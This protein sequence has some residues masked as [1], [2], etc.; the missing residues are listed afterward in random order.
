MGAGDHG[1]DESARPESRHARQ[2]DSIALCAFLSVVARLLGLRERQLAWGVRLRSSAR[3]SRDGRIRRA[4][5][6][7]Q[8]I[9]RC[10]TVHTC[11]L[12]ALAAGPPVLSLRW[13]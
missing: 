8:D 5:F 6:R 1:G 2:A 3:R 12:Y 13:E 7:V 4:V 10:R 9:E 11:P